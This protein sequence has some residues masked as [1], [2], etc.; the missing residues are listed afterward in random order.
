MLR[1]LVEGTARVYEER[2]EIEEPECMLRGD[3]A[4]RVVVRFQ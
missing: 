4:C 2:V 3:P 1:G